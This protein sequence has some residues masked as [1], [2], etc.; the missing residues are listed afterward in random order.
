[1]GSSPI[2][3]TGLEVRT[4]DRT[5]RFQRERTETLHHGART[6]R[7]ALAQLI[8]DLFL[9]LR[10]P[11]DVIPIGQEVGDGSVDFLRLAA[12]PPIVPPSSIE[13]RLSLRP[14]DTHQAQVAS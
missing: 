9:P 3:G 8:P 12:H 14:R 4:S 13:R 1:M 11:I 5:P 2:A 6:M 10:K 7:S